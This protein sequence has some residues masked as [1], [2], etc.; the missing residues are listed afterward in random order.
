MS[1]S[2]SAVL[3]HYNTAVL[4]DYALMSLDWDLK[5]EPSDSESRFAESIRKDVNLKRVTVLGSRDLQ[6]KACLY[7]DDVAVFCC[8]PLSMCR[9]MS[10]C[11]QFE[12]ISRAKLY[13]GRFKVMFFGNWADCTLIPFTVRTDNLKALIGLALLLWNAPNSWTFPYHLSFTKKFAKKSICDHQSVRKW[14]ARN[15]LETLWKKERVNPVRMFPEQ[16]VKI[17]WQNASSPE[18]SNRHQDIAWLVS[19]SVTL[20][21]VHYGLFPGTYIETNINCACRTINSV[22]D[23]LWSARNLLVLQGTELTLT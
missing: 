13:R 1:T 23:S 15:V 9:L 7:V 10:I 11:D 8:D 16:T 14:S 18:L 20:D 5:P 12:L 22:K 2:S 6:V 19:S 3:P 21:F 4:K 17:I